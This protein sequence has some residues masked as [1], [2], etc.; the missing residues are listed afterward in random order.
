MEVVIVPVFHGIPPYDFMNSHHPAT[1]HGSALRAQQLMIP[2]AHLCSLTMLI[3]TLQLRVPVPTNN[4]ERLH[5][6][7]SVYTGIAS[8]TLCRASHLVHQ[9]CFSI[10]SSRSFSIKIMILHITLQRLSASTSSKS[11]MLDTLCLE[12][13]REFRQFNSHGRLTG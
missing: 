6:W 2:P 13:R 7:A 3:S 5:V 1:L 4:P 8:V 10:P 11:C 9:P 12:L